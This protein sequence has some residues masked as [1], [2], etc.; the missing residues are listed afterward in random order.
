[1]ITFETIINLQ[2][3]VGINTKIKTTKR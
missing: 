3:K 1:M 2:R